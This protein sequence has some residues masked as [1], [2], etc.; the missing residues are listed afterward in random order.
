MPTQT[1]PLRPEMNDS[2]ANDAANE[3]V[4]ADAKN[5][6]AKEAHA[7]LAGKKI[8]WIEDD[9]FLGN[10]LKKR[11]SGYGCEMILAINGDEAFAYLGKSMPHVIV[12]DLVLP[13]M[14]GFD[15]LKKIRDN[16]ALKD[17]PVLIL[18]NLNQ[19]ADIERAKI[20]GAEKYLVK[21]AVSL[22]EI[23]R[24]VQLLAR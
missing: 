6:A 19:P 16:Q 9:K 18:S 1:Q 2:D 24:Q 13:G 22:D 10:I 20:L 23:V 15:I 8:L 17:V 5:N 7:A 14:S 3:A 12:L 21:A 4:K 11:V